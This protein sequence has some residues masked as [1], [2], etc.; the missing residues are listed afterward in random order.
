MA[1]L[2]DCYAHGT[3]VKQDPAEAAAWYRKAADKGDPAGQFAYANCLAAGTGIAKNEADAAK[4]L[5]DAV[6]QNHG[7]ALVK[8]GQALM[9]ASDDKREEAVQL[10]KKAADKDDGVGQYELGRCYEN[11]TGV[12]KDEREAVGWYKKSARA[13]YVNGQLAYGKCLLH[14]VGVQESRGLANYW[15]KLAA[16]QGSDEAKKLITK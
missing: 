2:G 1:S 8:K 13:G 5:G 4:W 15:I 14:G 11:G 9:A 6:G 3:G 7:P 12:D 10:F 16:Q